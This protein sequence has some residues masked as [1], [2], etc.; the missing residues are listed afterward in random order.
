MEEL[1]S[2]AKDN[3]TLL[4]E[5]LSENSNDFISVTASNLKASH[6]LD[7]D[8]EVLSTSTRCGTRRILAQLYCLQRGN[9]ELLFM[10]NTLTNTF[11]VNTKGEFVANSGRL[12]HSGDA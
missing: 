9:N 6:Y 5:V 1:E 2:R 8:P 12:T 3:Y 10:D 4:H 7:G 11:F